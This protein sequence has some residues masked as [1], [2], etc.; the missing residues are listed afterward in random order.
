MTSDRGLIEHRARSWRDMLV[1]SSPALERVVEIIRLAAPRRSTVL[2]TGE[3]GTGKEVAAQAIHAASDRCMRP[4]VAVN[5]GAIPANLVE[6]EL[7]G[8]VRGAFTGA[9]QSRTG[10][11]EEAQ[12]GTILLDEVS[13]LPLELQGKLLRVLQERE[14]QRL[15]SS[16]VTHLDIRV[17]AAT[18]CDLT[19]AVRKREF[20][21]D[22]YYRLNVVPLRMP[23]LRDRVS[24]IA[25]LADHFLRAICETEGIPGKALS[26]GAVEVMQR[27]PW[28]GNVRQLQHA[29]EMAVVLSGD[30]ILLTAS[31]FALPT[32]GASPTGV[33]RAMPLTT[34]GLNFDEEVSRFERTILEQAL[35]ACGGN[36][37]R[38][39]EL[40]HMKRTT[41][42]AKLKA[43]GLRT[44][45]EMQSACA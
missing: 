38:T 16:E 42:L 15:G 24:D 43:L 1:G 41:L 28:P 5:C 2:V 21:E 19:E 34:A 35:S 3:T 11:F 18:N 4:M 22:L 20:R 37:A 14:V 8:Y 25:Q 36:K 45:D 6:S 40:L 27:H 32:S 9:M 44:A 31:D 17:I 26:E 30:R 23:P 7:F 39:A 29:V 10:R 12:G 13:E 33:E